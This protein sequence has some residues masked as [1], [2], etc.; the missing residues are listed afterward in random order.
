MIIIVLSLHVVVVCPPPARRKHYDATQHAGWRC[1]HFRV[2][3]LFFFSD[4][5]FFG[6][7][8]IVLEIVSTQLL[9]HTRHLPTTIFTVIFFHKWNG[10]FLLYL[11]YATIGSTI[12]SAAEKPQ[13]GLPKMNFLSLLNHWNFLA[14]N[15]VAQ[16]G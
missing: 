2:F 6:C 5:F 3:F 8:R 1:N 12:T 9:A 4:P 11:L 13:I 10:P 7:A 15:I 16:L 14:C